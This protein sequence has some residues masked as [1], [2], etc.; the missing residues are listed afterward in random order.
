MIDRLIVSLAA[1]LILLPLQAAF[2]D[3]GQ[4]AIIEAPT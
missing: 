2:A 1:T 4:V 3:D